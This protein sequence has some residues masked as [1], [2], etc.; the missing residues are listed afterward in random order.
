MTWGNGST[1]I[2]GTVSAANSLVGTTEPPSNVSYVGIGVTTLSNGNYVVDSPGWNGVGAATWGNG[3]TGISGTISSANSLVGINPFDLTGNYGSV[4]PLSNGNY[5]VS[6]GRG[7]TWAN[8]TSG[9]TLDGLNTI[10][11]QNTVLGVG[12]SGG[13]PQVNDDP[14]EQSFLAAGINR[15]TV[16]LPDPNLFNYA[17]SQ[18]QSVT[19]TPQF[20]TNTLNSGTAVVLQASN[21]ITVNDPITVTAGGNGGA[22]TLQAGR[23][24]VL[25]ANITTDNGALTLIANDE[26]ANGVVDDERDP[27]NAVISM[28]AGTALDTGSGTL[29]AELSDGAGLTNADSGAITLQSVTAGLVSVVNSGTSAGSDVNLGP[30]TTSGEQSY[31]DPNGTTHVTGNLTAGDSLIQFSDAVVVSDGVTVDAGVSTVNFAS[32]GTQTLQSG[33]GTSFDN[34]NHTGTGTL[35]L[36]S[37]LTVTGSFTNSAG[38]FDAND[39]P[40]SVAGSAILAGGTYLAGTAPQT[41]N[42]GLSITGG[43]FTS[44]TGPLSVSGGITLSS[45]QLSGVGT[46]DTVTAVGGTLAPGGSTPGVLAVSGA[47]TLNSSATLSVLLNGTDAG[48]GYAQLQAGGPIDLG[49]ST[50]SLQFGFTPPVGSS[51][52]ILTNTGA[53]PITGTFNG[54]SEGV[55]FTQG[56]YQFQITY[57][58]GTGGDSVVLTRLA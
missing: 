43:L 44:S 20:L 45:G 46:V 16:G 30:V 17:R 53:A 3:S 24:I 29:T 4:T 2:S 33:N 48:T 15:V 49:Q 8:G 42:G 37:G 26:L 51:F 38:T 50:L 34:V 41:F 11:P 39:Q 57:Q 54:L 14:A 5:V 55:V 28:A 52:E 35:Q 31:A 21:D 19:V 12:Y 58:G 47:V 36:T 13:A 25:N 40:V 9:Q 27:G 10:T 56:A 18:A 32:T 6:S 22:L 23:S 7:A 1:G